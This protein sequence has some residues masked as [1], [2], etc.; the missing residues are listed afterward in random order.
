MSTSNGDIITAVV[1]SNVIFFN[2]IA[3]MPIKQYGHLTKNY[4]YYCFGRKK[5]FFQDFV[6]TTIKI[7]HCMPPS[8]SK[9]FRSRW[10]R[11]QNVQIR[12]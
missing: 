10:G 5:I 12:L 9:I 4:K 8:R 1:H 3:E 7:E 11:P 2:N 6:Y